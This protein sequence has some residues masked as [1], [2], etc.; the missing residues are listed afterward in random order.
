MPRRMYDSV[1][2]QNI[3]ADARMVAGYV[4]GAYAWPEEAWRKF[5]KAAHVRI[6]VIPPG[7]PAKAGVLD[8]ETG[9]ASVDD[10]PGFIRA[11]RRH[12]EPA[13]IYVERSLVPDI[14]R[15]CGDLEY[16]LWV[17]DWTGHPHKLADMHK[18]VAVQWQGGVDVPYDISEVFARTWHPQGAAR[19]AQ[20]L[21]LLKEF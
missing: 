2:W 20:R 13:V 10:A 8:V 9:A 6:S 18:V 7:D 14:R 19:V 4:D 12:K 17:A 3:P 15:A 16:G 21:G 1:D 5:P 11:R